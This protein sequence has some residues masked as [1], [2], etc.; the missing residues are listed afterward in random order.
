[1]AL[2]ILI[3][4]LSFQPNTR[5]KKR[6]RRRSV[7]CLKYQ[8]L[9]CHVGQKPSTS[10]SATSL[11]YQFDSESSSI[12]IGPDVRCCFLKLWVRCIS[13]PWKFCSNARLETLGKVPSNGSQ[14][15]SSYIVSK[16]LITRLQIA[17]NR[18][19]WIEIWED[20][21]NLLMIDLSIRH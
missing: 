8:I 14:E 11:P 2:E 1:M 3:M 20:F 21:F 18:D 13:N 19:L 6:K 16:Y 17:T 4:A 7:P 5:I 15:A 9:I 12:Y 10:V